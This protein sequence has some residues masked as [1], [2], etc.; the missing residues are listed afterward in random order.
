VPAVLAIGNGNCKHQKSM[1]CQVGHG[2]V[3]DKEIAELKNV[4]DRQFFGK[5]QIKHGQEI[6]PIVCP[7]FMW[8]WEDDFHS[9]SYGFRPE[10]SV[11]HAIRTVKLPLTD[12]HNTK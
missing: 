10:R 9:L 1:L 8:N 5:N 12:S 4:L 11:H 7:E 6:L 2:T 3:R